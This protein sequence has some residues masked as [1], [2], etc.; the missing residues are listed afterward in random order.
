[1]AEANNT[2]EFVSKK[3]QEWGFG[4]FIDNFRREQID[5]DSFKL[6][7]MDTIK[8]LI[9]PAGPRLKFAKLLAEYKSS[10]EEVLFDITIPVSSA[11]SDSIDLTR[12]SDSTS[13]SLFASSEHSFAPFAHTSSNLVNLDLRQILQKQ[14]LTILSLLIEKKQIGWCDKQRLNRLFVSAFT[15][16]YGPFPSTAQKASLAQLII[17]EF[18]SL[19]GHEGRGYEQW[20]CEG[21]NGSASSGLIEDRIRNWRKRLSP[22]DKAAFKVQS[23]KKKATD[24][25]NKETTIR[26]SGKN[27]EISQEVL[28]M[29]QWLKEN[30]TPKSIVIERMRDTA[31]AR[32][33][34]IFDKKHTLTEILD[35]WPRLL[36]PEII[37]AE[38]VRRYSQQQG[39]ALCSEFGLLSERI[40]FQ[41]KNC[42][43]T[44]AEKFAQELSAQDFDRSLTALRLLPFLLPQTV[45][46]FKEQGK[47]ETVRIKP[48]SQVSK[49]HFI[50]V[51]PVSTGFQ[52][53]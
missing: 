30:S 2:K 40:I 37:D 49:L 39:D 24:D 28:Q 8:V 19:T 46:L 21:R 51:V 1:M 11:T 14:Y 23:R 41:A 45:V 6:L 18:P 31:A 4:D 35:A 27:T 9:P 16:K 5:Q 48:T 12:I 53:I 17:Q 44:G 52:F 50:D 36:E 42:G 7:D 22:G 25:C 38:F 3:L 32:D 26:H 29:Q 34:F 10:L 33:V 47:K 13:C 20:F 43:R 15:D